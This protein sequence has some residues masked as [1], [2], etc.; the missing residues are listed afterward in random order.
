MS[1]PS[2]TSSLEAMHLAPILSGMSKLRV[3]V[4]TSNATQQSSSSFLLSSKQVRSRPMNA[5]QASRQDSSDSG[6]SGA[7]LA[8]KDVA[9]RQPVALDCIG[10]CL[11]NVLLSDE[12]GKILGTILSGDDLVHEEIA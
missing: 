8:G 10:E 11:L 7:A 2:R 9:V 5:I 1:T 6:F 12:L 4:Q 3:K